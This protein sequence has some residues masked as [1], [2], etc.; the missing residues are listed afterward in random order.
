MNTLIQ[1]G[2]LMLPPEAPIPLIVPDEDG[3]VYVIEIPRM[4]AESF[5]FLVSLLDQYKRAIVKSPAEPAPAP[6]GDVGE[7]NENP[8]RVV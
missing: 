1:R 8:S 6:G 4:S 7:T 2:C 5:E 3:V